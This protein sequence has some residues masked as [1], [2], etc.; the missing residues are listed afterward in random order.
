MSPPTPIT[1]LM[2]GVPFSCCH[3]TGGLKTTMSPRL[4]VSNRGVSL[5]TSTYWSGSSVVSIDCCRIWYGWATK[6]WMTKKM[7][8][9]RT[10]VSTISKRHPTAG[11]LVTSPA[12]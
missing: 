8:R 9:V 3:A 7:M 12:V 10:S 2:Y 11:R 4:Y 6:V 1:R 5:S